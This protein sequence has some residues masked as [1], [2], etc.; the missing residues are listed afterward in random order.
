MVPGHL[1]A[2]VV[3]DVLLAQGVVQV[4][5]A[6]D[7]VGHAEEMI[8]D[9]NR[10]VH[11]RVDAVT[12]ADARMG[13]LHDAQTDEVPDGRVR[14]LE[15]GLDHD[16]RL[17]LFEVAGEHLIEH[18]Q[19]RFLGKVAVGAGLALLLHLPPVVGRTGADVCRVLL[20][21]LPGD[22][23]VKIEPVGLDDGLADL[24]AHPFQVLRDHL[25]RVRIDLLRV[26]VLH[27]VDEDAVVPLAILVVED[28]D[29]GV[30]QVQRSRRTGAK[31]MTTLPSVAPGRSGRTWM[32]STFSFLLSMVE[33]IAFQLLALVLD[34]HAVDQFR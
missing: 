28:G 32:R 4:V 20:D 14:V 7:D 22:I 1:P 10:E 16:D 24:H 23:V 31:R 30:A 17:F 12:G 19:M 27:P 6:P 18:L 21:E 33:S 8:V 29:P 11:G 13:L 2:E 26:G 15:V 5:D 9:R 25:V 3:E 34:R